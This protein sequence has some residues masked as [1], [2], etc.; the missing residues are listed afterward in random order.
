MIKTC[1]ALDLNDEILKTE[2]F[3][4]EYEEMKIRAEA[5]ENIVNRD[6]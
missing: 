2:H 5:P 3:E 1:E 4:E 6:S